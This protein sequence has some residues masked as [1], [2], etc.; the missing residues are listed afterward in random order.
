VWTE[1]Y[2]AQAVSL[3][4]FRLD[5]AYLW[6]AEPSWLPDGLARVGFAPSPIRE[7][8]YVLTAYYVRQVDRMGLLARLSDDR[9]FGNR[10]VTVDGALEVSRD[11]LD[12]ILEISFLER[13]LGLSGLERPTI[14]DVGAGYGRLAHRLAEALPNLGEV[15]C[16]DAVAASTFI[17]EHYLRLRG[18]DD[19]A[20]VAPLDEIEA[21]LAERRVDVAVNVHS[22]SECSVDA[23]CW[24]L[25]LLRE[26]RVRYLL[27][28]PSY[29]EELLTIERGWKL[30]SFAP[31]LRDR[32]YRR[33]TCEPKYA[34][35][36]S[37]QRFGIYPTYYHLFELD[38][39]EAPRPSR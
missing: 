20:R 11:L 18:V 14:L 9:L 19:V 5:S 13:T 4:R 30:K 1:D 23:I 24:W 17:S 29:H 12:S 21:V 8:N 16:T 37:V 39:A 33:V 22:F 27:V 6:Q 36:P 28:V 10:I 15:V 32:G 38:R 35:A 26:H 25:D 7:L 2:V 31:A 3:T 34:G